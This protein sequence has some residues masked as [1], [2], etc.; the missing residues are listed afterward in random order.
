MPYGTF[1]AENRLSSSCF[2]S[3]SEIQN[4]IVKTIGLLFS[5]ASHTGGTNL[6][7]VIQHLRRYGTARLFSLLTV[8]IIAIFI[9]A[10]LVACGSSTG[11]GG[12]ATP[13]TQAQT[14]NCGT[15]ETTPRGMPM[16]Q[17]TAQQSENCFFQTYQHCQNA[18]LV[19]GLHGVDTSVVRTFTI[20]N[21]NGRCTIL[22]AMQHSI[23]PAPLSPAKTFQCSTVSMQADGLH[24]TGC[25]QDGDNGSIVILSHVNTSGQ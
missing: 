10:A 11:S 24:I 25:G 18:T 17:T 15:I 2:E 3:P 13:T 20:E 7:L 12:S 21:H 19:Y 5:C 9:S 1:R 6:R 16:N 4:I 23:A 8:G 14:Q 22:D